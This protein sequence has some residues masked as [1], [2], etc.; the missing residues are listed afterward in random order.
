MCVGRGEQQDAGVGHLRL[1]LSLLQQLLE[2][3]RID[4]VIQ[5]ADRARRAARALV[6][7]VAPRL[8]Q[9]VD[10]EYDGGR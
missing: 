3:L 7:Q 2:H 8:V 1:A 10:V 6:L 4:R 5:V 9:I